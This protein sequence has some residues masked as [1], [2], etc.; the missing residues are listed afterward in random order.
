MANREELAI[1][2]NARAGQ[3]AAQLELGKLYLFG[4]AGLPQSLPTA[5]HWLERAAR[6]ECQPAWQLIGNHIPLELAQPCAQALAPWYERAYD[7]G[8]VHAGLVFAQ[9]VFNGAGTGTAMPA[10][11]DTGA[12]PDRSKALRA[13]EDAARA[14]FPEAQWLLA[15]QHAVPAQAAAAGTGAAAGLAP[16]QGWLKRAADNGVAQAQYAVLDQAWKNGQHSDYL[17]R[18]LPLA[19]ALVRSVAVQDGVQ[20]LAPGDIALLSRV[21]RLLDAGDH[22]ATLEAGDPLCFWELAAAEHERHAQLAMGLRCARMGI[23]GRR[24]TGGS[25]G[26]ANFK[27]AIRWLTLAGE[28]GLAEAWYA[29]SRIY[30]KPEFSQRS[31]GDAQRYLERAAD[32]GYRE[33][34]LECGNIAWRARRENENNDVRAVFW[35]QKAA[36]QGCVEAAGLLRKIAPRLAGPAYVET[37]KL[38]SRNLELDRTHPLL[39]ARLE[40][41]GLFKLSR[42]E[43]LLLD[44]PAADHGHCLVIDIRSSYG[45][46]KRRLVLVEAAPER[47][48]LDR[49]ARLFEGIDCG[50]S[51]PEGNYRQR[52]YRLRTLL[53]A[54][55]EEA[56]VQDR[57]ESEKDQQGPAGLEL[58]A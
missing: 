35:L 39:A 15:R 19:R 7:D 22:G 55:D 54:Q 34:Q 27:K 42:A 44:V 16:S 40:L 10:R 4:S 1:I 28:Q 43:A 38:L 6:Q 52:L 56:G 21:A 13:L 23:D 26:A 45:R 5:L 41:A 31:V 12:A 46:S 11:D 51:G 20:R 9:L 53:G 30:I 17:V 47:H 18:A 2:R 50:P 57:K 37:G 58:A 32:M 3:A 33:A 36:G 48:A 29:L 49:I 24:I 14:G 8:S 25:S